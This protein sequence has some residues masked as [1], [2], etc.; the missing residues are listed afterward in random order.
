M[1]IGLAGTK[2]PALDRVVEQAPHTI[3][4]VLVILGRIDAPL[5]GDGM[6]P[7]GTVVETESLHPITELGQRGRRRGPGQTGSH[8]DHLIFPFVGR[9]DQAHR[10]LEIPPLVGQGAGR[11]A[12]I[13][14]HG[15]QNP[16]ITATGM[17]L[18]PRK[19]TTANAHEAVSISLARFRSRMPKV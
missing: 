3:A 12:G 2:I 13:E 7:P 18:N 14:L 11:N 19:R 8:H 9:A 6:R 1:N 15:F 17:E 5:G 10:G 16:S 4:V